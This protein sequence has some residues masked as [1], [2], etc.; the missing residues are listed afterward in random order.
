VLGYEIES[1]GVQQRLMER[2]VGIPDGAPSAAVAASSLKTYLAWA[3]T[4]AGD[5]DLADLALLL[6]QVFPPLGRDQA[7]TLL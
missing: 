6:S 1:E 5:A 2:A 7:K 3:K 4:K